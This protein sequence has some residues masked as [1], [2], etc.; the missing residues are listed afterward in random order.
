MNTYTDL[1][2]QIFPNPAS[3]RAYIRFDGIVNEPVTIRIIN[4][5]GILIRTEKRTSVD[6]MITLDL[7]GLSSGLYLLSVETN[8]QVVTKKLSVVK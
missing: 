8:N 5:N 4:A 2:V 3:S 7:T 6:R 1:A